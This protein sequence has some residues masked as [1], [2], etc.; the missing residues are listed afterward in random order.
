V[1]REKLLALD[2][3]LEFHQPASAEALEELQRAISVSVPGDLVALLG[4]TNGVGDRYGAGLV[5]STD[6][7]LAYNESFR[8]APEFAELYMPFD[9]LLFFADAGNGDQFAFPITAAG[10]R[11]DVFVWDH[12]SDSRRWYAGSLAQ[13]L[14]WWLSGEH[15][16]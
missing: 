15:P 16:V 12:E 2:P 14:S 10:I 1:W 3:D 6:R 8:A 13:D 11:D 4:E 5:W 9:P 7:I